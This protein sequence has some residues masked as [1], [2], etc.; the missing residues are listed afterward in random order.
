MNKT[1]NA[2]K[3]LL[4]DGP[5]SIMLVSGKAEAFGY[6]IKSGSSMVVREGKRLP[7]VVEE[8]AVFNVSLGANANIQEVEGSTIPHSWTQ[9]FRMLMDFQKRPVTVVVVGKIDSG[10]TSFAMY[11]VNKLLSTKQKAVIL[12]GDL[13][14][15]DVGPPCAVAYA[16]ATKPVTDFLDLEVENA[17][18]VGTTSPGEAVDKAIQG[19]VS[20]KTEIMCRTVD[21]V[22]VNTDGWVEG[23]DAV[24]YKLRLIS[25]LNPDIA[26]GIQEENELIPLLAR[27]DEFKTEVVDS[28]VAVQ[29]RSREKRKDIRERSYAKCL[30]GAKTKSFHLSQLVIERGT[31]APNWQ[32]EEGLLVGL[33]DWQGKFLGI[34]ILRGVDYARKE[35]KIFTPVSEKPSRIVIGKVRLDWKL[36]ETVPLT[37]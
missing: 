24:E 7:F 22:V 12:D 20:I 18:F 31:L 4:V 15:S 29:Q 25:A 2:G 28:P 23:E 13:G 10:K 5:A 17:Y 26:F 14:Q 30:T 35:L 27:L 8:T 34:G 11:L 21:F 9:A 36:K 1:V 37:K 16:F 3:T 33:Y 19:N 6:Q 32:G